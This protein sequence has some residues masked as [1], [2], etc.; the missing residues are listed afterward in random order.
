VF[1]FWTK[2]G[3]LFFSPF[4]G[5]RATYTVNLG[6]IEKLTVD[7]LPGVTAEVLRVNIDWKSAFWRGGSIS[8]TFYVEVDVPQEPFLHECLTTLSLTVFTQRNF[9]ADS[10]QMKCTFW[11]KTAILWFEP[12]KGLRGNV[13][14]SL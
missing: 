14:C 12:P 7:F 13:C 8:A 1:K 9:V 4:G 2:N 3:T 10:L 11:R 5:L 6:L